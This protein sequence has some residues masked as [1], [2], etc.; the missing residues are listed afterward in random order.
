MCAETARLQ[1]EWWIIT[2][3]AGR[4]LRGSLQV[5]EAGKWPEWAEMELPFQTVKLQQC[6]GQRSTACGEK[7]LTLRMK[8]TRKERSGEN[9]EGVIFEEVLIGEGVGG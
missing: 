8:A 6:S 5:H 4:L 9:P 7:L 3:W 2:D 1:S